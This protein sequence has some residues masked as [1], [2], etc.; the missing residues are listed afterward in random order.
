L[1]AVTAG[2]DFNLLCKVGGD[3]QH[4]FRDAEIFFFDIEMSNCREKPVMQ[5]PFDKIII[6]F[7]VSPVFV[8]IK[9][10]QIRF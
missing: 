4:C 7:N 10:L 1:A 2:K 5:N 6:C 3:R 8:V 9:M